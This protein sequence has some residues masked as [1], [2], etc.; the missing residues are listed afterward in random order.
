MTD[1]IGEADVW[2]PSK[3]ISEQVTLKN[4][5]THNEA[6]GLARTGDPLLPTKT[7]ISGNQKIKLR[8][9]GLKG[10]VSAQQTIITNNAYLVENNSRVRWGKKNKSNDEKLKNRFDE[11]NSDYH[12]LED[13]TNFLDDCEQQIIN[14]IKTKTPKDDF[15]IRIQDHTGIW[16]LELTNKFFYMMKRLELSFKEIMG[17]MLRNK[18]ISGGTSEDE[19]VSYKDQ[20]NLFLERFKES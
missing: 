7:P 11:S 19:E 2:N 10:M 18:I 12:E 16:V 6:M 20:E 15:I 17:I 8:F 14:A 1:N 4:I 3:Q 5:T 13:I 9:K